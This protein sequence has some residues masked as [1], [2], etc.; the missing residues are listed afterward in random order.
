MSEVRKDRSSNRKPAGSDG[1]IQ[2][3]NVSRRE[4]GRLVHHAQDRSGGTG[5]R[6]GICRNERTQPLERE[7]L[8]AHVLGRCDTLQ[9]PG[10]FVRHFK[11]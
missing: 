2:F 9:C 5:A 3:V 7:L 1:G 8:D 4:V 11:G 6:F 10:E